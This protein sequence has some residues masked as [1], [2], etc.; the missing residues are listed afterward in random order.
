[1]G[2]SDYTVFLIRVYVKAFYVIERCVAVAVRAATKT[3][4][5]RARRVKFSELEKAE[6]RRL[7]KGGM[8]AA[9]IARRLNRSAGSV[10][11][12]LLQDRRNAIH[13]K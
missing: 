7:Q 13:K 4:P 10:G 5:R 11:S 3:P 12:F 8:G 1:L 2:N 9:E 6:M